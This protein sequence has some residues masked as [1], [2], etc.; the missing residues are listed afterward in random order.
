M[1]AFETRQTIARIDAQINALQRKRR[2]LIGEVTTQN[3]VL[4]LCEKL[5]APIR[6]VP[7]DIFR[8]I[9]LYSLPLRPTPSYCQFPLSFSQVCSTWRSIALS[10]PRMWSTIYLTIKNPLSF[11][12]YSELVREW[13][14]RANP[15]PATFLI[16]FRLTVHDIMQ[17]EVDL[18]QFLTSLSQSLA[19]VRHLGFGSYK[20]ETL[21]AIFNEPLEWTLPTLCQLDI[22][23]GNATSCTE[24]ANVLQ[25]RYQLF[26]STPLLK[27]LILDSTIRPWETPF[28]VSWKQLTRLCLSQTT[29]PQDW[30]M[31]MDLCKDL[32]TCIVKLTNSDTPVPVLSPPPTHNLRSL[33]IELNSS[34]SQLT[35]ISFLS[36]FQFPQLTKLDLLCPS[37]HTESAPFTYDV[38]ELPCLTHLSVSGPRSAQERVLGILSTTANLVEFS[39]T[40]SGGVSSK[41]LEHLTYNSGWGIRRQSENNLPRLSTLRIDLADGSGFGREDIDMLKSMF[42]SRLGNTLP[43]GCQRLKRVLINAPDSSAEFF[44]KSAL[45]EWSKTVDVQMDISQLGPHFCQKLYVPRVAPFNEVLWADK[46]YV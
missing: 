19:H 26:K 8:E 30:I 9:A 28:F 10:T 11:P 37:R 38:S 5:R 39:I 42:S 12:M 24:S 15:I 36:L 33:S 46:S 34:S 21:R 45:F 32:Q 25:F 29:R 18:R 35:F 22:Q 13:L 7:Q 31:V 40:A 44:L 27:S 4:Q 2:E 43:T 17:C 20:V 41:L 1:A 23:S 3:S 6:R 14:K 16:Y